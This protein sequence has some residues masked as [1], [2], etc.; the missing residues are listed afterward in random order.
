MKIAVYGASGYTGKLVVAE[1]RRR[2]IDTVLVGRSAD[3]LQEAAAEA[4][5]PEATS[6]QAGIDE[7]DTL[8][9]AFRD[10]DVV[11]NCVALFRRWGAAV[12]RAAIGA[13]SH[14]LDISGEQLY[15]MQIFDSLAEPARRAGTTVVPMVND[16][17]FLA[18]L[19]TGLTVARLDHVDDIVVAHRSAG[20]P[21][22]SRGSG[23]TALANLDTFEDGGVVYADGRWC[24]GTPA[25]HTS[26]TFPGEAE[27]S[28]MVRFAV[29]EIATIPRHV[30]ARRLEGVTDAGLVARFAALTPEL[31]ESLPEGPAENLRGAGRFVLVVDA[32]ANAGA[33]SETDGNAGRARGLIE[34]TDTYGTTAVIAVEAAHRL[35]TDGA[36]P[37]VLAPT[38]AFEAAGFLDYLAPHGVRWSVAAR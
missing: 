13:R 28:P 15:I 22:L 36:E 29:P 18:D 3:R 20:S 25:H 5:A 37:G 12:A 33:E 6:R 17:G 30:P 10:C 9:T 8:T 38:Q 23:R 16:G 21:G 27:P 19:L 14:Y 4:G 35:A 2:K 11:L 24:S 7:P 1:L 32:A 34:G 31:V 26:I